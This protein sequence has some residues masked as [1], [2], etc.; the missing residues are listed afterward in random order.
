MLLDFFCIFSTGGLILWFKQFVN[1]KYES[2]INYIIK[3]ILL[4]QKRTIDSLSINGTVLRW[5]ISDENNLVFIVAYQEAYSLL[6]VD[7]L[8][9]MVM[10]D[11]LKNEI[12]KISKHNN[13]YFD[14]HDFS[15]RFMEILNSWENDCNKI[16]I[17]GEEAK[18]VK[19]TYKSKGK[20]I[21]KKE[22]K[23][24]IDAS[25]EKNEEKSETT[26]ISTVKTAVSKTPSTLN[27]NISKNVQMK[28]M[29]S[30]GKT[31]TTEKTVT[32]TP[33]KKGKE[34][35]QKQEKQEYSKKLENELNM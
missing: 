31:E 2:L 16:L 18:Q 14:G 28:R 23:K 24:S 20:E 6:Y 35:T 27:P 34:K 30:S 3:T 19:D 26:N 5:K 33:V 9:S 15:K 4:D 1:V 11:F 7:R 12:S 32:P 29:K 22:G 17:G 21:K 8:V 25:T 13:L 10:N